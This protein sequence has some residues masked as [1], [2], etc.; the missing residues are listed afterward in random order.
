MLGYSPAYTLPFAP[1]C[2]EHCT[3]SK[4]GTGVCVDHLNKLSIGRVEA[5]FLGHVIEEWTGRIHPLDHDKE[6][7]QRRKNSHERCM[8][9]YCK[10]NSVKHGSAHFYNSAIIV[11]QFA[12]C[13]P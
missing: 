9:I 7:I 5:V 8:T 10:V 11:E 6:A 2:P 1:A 3:Y 13:F 12:T 4:D